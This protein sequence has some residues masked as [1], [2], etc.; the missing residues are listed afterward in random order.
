MRFDELSL[1]SRLINTINNLGYAAATEIQQMCI[2]AAITG[3]DIIASSKTGSGKTMAFLLPMMQR[4]LRE[5][6]RQKRD[7][8]AVILAPTR[9]LARQV[10]AQLRFLLAG[11]QMEAALLL[12]GENF[13]DQ[14]HAL[15]K[16][17]QIII[18]TPGR[19]A[20]HLKERSIY[21]NGVEML[22]MD[23]ADRMLD[24]GFAAELKTINESADHRLRQTMMFSATITPEVEVL[25][26]AAL[27]NPRRIAV[28]DAMA[29]HADI[30]QHFYLVDHLDH[31]QALL[32]HILQHEAYQQ[33]IVFTATRA[34]TE[35]LAE[36]L[37]LQGS[38]AVGLSGEH[39]QSARNKIMDDFSRGCYK[40]LITTD[41]AS[42]G[43][44]L[45]N[46]SLVINFDM[47][48]QPE[49]YIHRIGRTGRAGSKG[50]A[51]SLVGPK[52]WESYERVKAAV[53]QPLSFSS[54]EGLEGKFRGL[55]KAK[56]V[57]DQNSTNKGKAAKS[58]SKTSAKAKP[59]MGKKF[60]AGT[61]AGM[62]MMKRKPKQ[63]VVERPDPEL[64]ES[65]TE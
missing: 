52:D 51:I 26:F 56:K 43:L 49:E 22:I 31:K 7:P 17:P 42:R 53:N 61:D 25:A 16:H 40:M 6:A 4:L 3:R 9:E 46:V 55:R 10:Y 45:L 44:D 1:D 48:K 18:A 13:N 41:V 11:K 5:R 28:G 59:R 57:T 19:L 33:V 15:R 38:K 32:D 47:P 36:R 34:D 64:P 37:N 14:I 60:T 63:L 54:I 58:G 30:S 62:V 35:R 39:S 23:E 50:T 8:R 2:P 20:N 24:L 21:L 12:G 27:K 29:Q 65:D